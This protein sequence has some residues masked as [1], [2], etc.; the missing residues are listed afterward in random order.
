[1]AKKNAFEEF[2]GKEIEKN[3]FEEFGGKETALKKKERTS[4]QSESPSGNGTSSSETGASVPSGMPPISN[5][6]N[7]GIFDQKDDLTRPNEPAITVPQGQNNLSTAP[8]YVTTNEVNAPGSSSLGQQALD[9]ASQV[10]AGNK[11]SKSFM[12]GA[13][14]LAAGLARTPAYLGDLT[15]KTLNTINPLYDAVPSTRISTDMAKA[16]NPVANYFENVSSNIDKEVDANY[17]DKE[18]KPLG[19]SD[20]FDPTSEH[21]DVSK[22]FSRMTT[23][24]AKMMPVAIGLA[25]G[26]ASGLTEAQLA[27]GGTPVFAAQAKQSLLEQNKLNKEQGLPE[28]SDEDVNN[29]SIVSGA[30]DGV[31]DALF[32]NVKF[33]AMYKNVFAKQGEEAAKKMVEEGAKKVM[34][35]AVKKYA[36]TISEEAISEGTQTLLDN[37]NHIYIGGDNKIKPMD[38]VME[39]IITAAGTAGSMGAP[40]IPQTA[41]QVART[42]AHATEAQKHAE[43]QAVLKQ[44]LADPNSPPEVRSAAQDGLEN[45]FKQEDKLTAQINKEH[46]DLPDTKK[47]DVGNHLVKEDAAHK[48]IQALNSRSDLTEDQK[49]KQTQVFQDQIDF[50]QKAVEDI[51][52]ENEKLIA[53]RDKEI[54][55]HEEQGLDDYDSKKF[56]SDHSD[57]EK[58]IKE[59][60]AKEKEKRDEE[61]KAEKEKK[62][63]AK[64]IAK[65][66][67]KESVKEPDHLIVAHAPTETTEKNITS[68]VSKEP[69]SEKGKEVAEKIG[70]QAKEEGVKNIITD[71]ETTRNKQTAE[72]AAEISG[73][74]VKEVEGLHTWDK[75]EF[76]GID[77]KDWKKSEKYFIEH[78]DQ[79]EHD[80]KKLN[81]SFNDFFERY[82]K[83]KKDAKENSN[84]KTLFVGSSTGIRLEKALEASNGEWTKKAKEHFLNNSVEHEGDVEENP[85]AENPAQE[86][87]D[88]LDKDIEAFK[89]TKPENIVKKYTAVNSRIDDLVEN[90]LL[91]KR[92]ANAYKKV[93][94]DMYEQKVKNVKEGVTKVG[95]DLKRQILGDYKG[96]VFSSML[97]SSPKMVADL[98][99]LGVK[100][101]HIYIDA[102]YS[103]QEA[104]QKSLEKLKKSPLYQKLSSAGVLDKKQFEKELTDKLSVAKPVEEVEEKK[105]LVNEGPAPIKKKERSIGKRILEQDKFKNVSERLKKKGIDYEVI[106]QKKA[107]QVANDIIAEYEKENA[108]VDLA[109]SIIDGTTDIPYNMQGIVAAKLTDRLNVIAEKETNKFTQDTTFQKSAELATWWMGK[110]TEAGQFNGVASAEISNSLPSSKEGLRTFAN[111]EVEKLHDTILSKEEKSEIASVTKDVNN[112]ASADEMTKEQKVMLES[113]VANKIREI[114]EKINGK[115]YV[116]NLREAMS[117]LKMDLTEC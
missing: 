52:R 37:L 41:L 73:A 56:E 108:I 27:A 48:A 51:Y 96:K 70:D 10:I 33:G 90:K 109:D 80:G 76:A 15:N 17:T 50:H 105:E 25:A 11:W 36:G 8:S 16:N 67:V 97:P 55:K 95:E 1:M 75:G 30:I 77:S 71:S 35:Q 47:F 110:A 64:K 18:G 63:E 22:G 69:L 87:L 60:L 21:F 39:S 3:P 115:E 112:L 98:I 62:S 5:D 31:G 9:K 81:E 104:V 107:G 74:K 86:H 82:T 66:K 6:L 91:G 103:V 94:Q 26:S 68:S 34:L 14:Q 114:S 19:A 29:V 40:I 61:L 38:G 57:L 78:P 2:G 93:F 7:Q 88:R 43:N 111:K 49:K 116:S 44:Q 85:D 20:F 99:D 12:S 32:G 28:M 24:A 101:A 58:E 59:E 100:F 13:A 65:V 117:S 72:T 45:S 113:L 4:L 46:A 42:S 83:A 102:N 84:G 79:V 89:V 23:N 54:E 106:N 92:T 53:E